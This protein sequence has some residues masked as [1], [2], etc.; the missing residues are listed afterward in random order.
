MLVGCGKPSTCNVSPVEIEELREDVAV[1]QK[2]LA[3]ARERSDNLAKE[4]ATKQADLDSK[5]AKPDELRARLEALRRG[6]GRNEKAKAA[7][8]KAAPK[9]AAPATSKPA[10]TTPPKPATPAPAPAKPDSTK[11]E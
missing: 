1:V 3:T 2:N 8:T 5:K 11:K 7:D 10:V 6:S 4:L 9:P